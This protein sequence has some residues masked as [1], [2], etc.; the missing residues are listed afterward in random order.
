MKMTILALGV[1]AMAALAGATGA[2]A[3]SAPAPLN[4]SRGVTPVTWY[5]Y[6]YYKPHYYGYGRDYG[7]RHGWK[8]HHYGYRPYYHDGWYKHRYW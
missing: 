7:W 5:G 1:A 6:H 4:D 2:S 3:F 8:R